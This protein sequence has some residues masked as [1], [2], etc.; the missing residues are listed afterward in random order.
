MGL[1]N[2]LRLKCFYPLSLMP[3]SKDLYRC[4]NKHP[5]QRNDFQGSLVCFP[6]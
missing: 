4:H 2:K 1:S 6:S 5:K 3:H